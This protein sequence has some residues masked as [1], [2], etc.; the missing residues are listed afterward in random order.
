MVSLCCFCCNPTRDNEIFAH[1]GHKPHKTSDVPPSVFQCPR[2]NVRGSERPGP[3]V[4]KRSDWLVDRDPCFMAYH[5]PYALYK[6]IGFYP[7]YI[8]NWVIWDTLPET[9]SKFAP[10]NRPKLPQEETN[11]QY[12]LHFRV[13]YVSFREGT[14]THPISNSKDSKPTKKMTQVL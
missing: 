7:L 14:T 9:N 12:S 6:W 2:S 8:Y 13:L 10:E 1:E 4:W 11:I 5:N 3:K